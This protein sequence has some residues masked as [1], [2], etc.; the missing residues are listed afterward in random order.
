MY[1]PR[2]VWSV[3]APLCVM[4]DDSDKLDALTRTSPADA[5]PGFEHRTF[6]FSKVKWKLLLRG[7]DWPGRHHLAVFMFSPVLSSSFAATELAR[8]HRKTSGRV[9]AYKIKET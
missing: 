4:V 5:I 8:H 1:L 9:P 6:V 3:P 2:N 7:G